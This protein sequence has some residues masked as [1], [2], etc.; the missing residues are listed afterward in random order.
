VICFDHTITCQDTFDCGAGSGD[1]RI[2]Q[3]GLILS[4]DTTEDR[5]NIGA[6]RIT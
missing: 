2:D 3:V 5:F 4:P 1:G 6:C